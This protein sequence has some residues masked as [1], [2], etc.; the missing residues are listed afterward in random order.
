MGYAKTDGIKTDTSWTLEDG[1][2]VIEQT[3][4]HDIQTLVNMEN[5][6]VNGMPILYRKV[7]SLAS[8]KAEKGTFYQEGKKIYCNKFDFHDYRRMIMLPNAGCINIRQTGEKIYSFKN[9]GFMGGSLNL[10][11]NN[12]NTRIYLDGCKFF[13]GLTDGFKIDGKYKVFLKDC[14]SAYPSKDC[15]NYHSTSKDSIAVEINC[16]GYGAGQYKFT[17]TN[18]DDASNNGSTAHNGMIILRFGSSYW[19]CQGAIVADIENCYSINYDVTCKDILP[20]TGIRA[21]FRITNDESSV[22]Y[23]D[24]LVNK[25]IINCYGGGTNTEYGIYGDEYTKVYGFSGNYNYYG[26]VDIKKEEFLNYE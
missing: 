16:K 25:Y 3:K 7:S 18:V 1:I 5:L 2:G 4:E 26:N 10:L 23:R 12:L 20:T 21:S 8:C 17:N 22:R 6:D 9:M 19:N 13:R 15:F 14:V 11:P 24:E